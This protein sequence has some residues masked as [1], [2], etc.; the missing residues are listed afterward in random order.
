MS[1][2]H[3]GAG[4][5]AIGGTLLTPVRRLSRDG[6][7]SREGGAMQLVEL[8]IL[9]CLVKDPAHC[10]RFQIPFQEE[11][12]MAQCSWHSQFQAVEWVSEHPD[13][14]LKRFT[15]EVPKA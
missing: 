1:T 3:N 2:C 13:W 9:A 12:N 10:E 15:C 5:P 8:V 4:A 6:G 11:M 7:G 14:T